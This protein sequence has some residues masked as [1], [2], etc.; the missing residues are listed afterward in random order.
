MTLKEISQHLSGS[1]NGTTIMEILMAIHLK[2]ALVKFKPL[3]VSVEGW[4]AALLLL[5]PPEPPGIGLSFMLPLGWHKT[6]TGS[7]GGQPGT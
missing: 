5:L 6:Y 7:Q 4:Q 3:A 2:S 1:F